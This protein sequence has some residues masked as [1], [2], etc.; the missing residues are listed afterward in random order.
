MNMNLLA[1]AIAWK[2]GCCA[3]TAVESDGKFKITAWRHKSISKPSDKE[4]KGLVKEYEAYLKTDKYENIKID[5]EFN[6]PVFKTM[7]ELIF[8]LSSETDMEVFMGKVRN[9]YKE[10][11]K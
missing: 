1:D 8:E 5:I 3:D 6:N 7:I 4:C 11:Y 9:K 2:Y 10:K